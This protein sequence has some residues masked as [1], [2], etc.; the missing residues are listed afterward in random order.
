MVFDSLS[1]DCQRTSLR[2]GKGSLSL[3]E[4]EK[5]I[6]GAVVS[7]KGT[8][9]FRTD[10][11]EPIQDDFTVAMLRFNPSDYE[12]LIQPSNAR[13]DE[14]PE[15]LERSQSTIDQSFRYLYH[16]GKEALI[17]KQGILAGVFSG[18]N[19]GPFLVHDD[20]EK[21]IVLLLKEHR[22]IYDGSKVA[23][24]P[25]FVIISNNWVQPAFHQGMD[26]IWR[27][28][29]IDLKGDSYY[30]LPAPV[31]QKPYS[32]RF[33][34]TSAYFQSWFGLYIVK[35]IQSGC[36]ALAD[37]RLDTNLI[38]RLFIADQRA[39]LKNIARIENPEVALDAAAPISI[40]SA[41]LSGLEGWKLN[42]RLRSN[43]DVGGRNVQSG[44]PPLF[45]VPPPLWN[46]HV[47]SYALARLD[48]V[49]YIIHN[50]VAKE[51]Y[52]LYYNGIDFVDK[53]GQRHKTLP[54]IQSELESMVSSLSM[55]KK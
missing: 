25:T 36:F 23:P 7:A 34:P 43:I 17:P 19:L 44:R 54:L 18:V 51:T 47:G 37:N 3:I 8:F 31:N 4:C 16:D 52:V 46:G 9:F 42:G 53:N 38:F 30:Y 26:G 21:P 55:P 29:G 2:F 49:V 22:R 41:H 14:K 1:V 45:L 40:S 5:G 13:K 15:T 48:V 12:A 24:P 35:D 28:E 50:T 20:G 11:S 10:D 6:T 27:R 39:W 33:D 32:Q